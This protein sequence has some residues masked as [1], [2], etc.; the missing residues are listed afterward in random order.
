MLP[1][2]SPPISTSSRPSPC[3][4]GARRRNKAGAA[5]SGHELVL[6]QSGV[7]RFALRAEAAIRQDITRISTISTIGVVLL[8]IALFRGLRLVLLS[9]VL[10]ATG[11]T[12]SRRD[13]YKLQRDAWFD[14]LT[15]R[16]FARA[17]LHDP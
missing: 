14:A 11:S 12:T 17:R 15:V 5:E 1:F 7:G 13:S 16:V 10:L 9:L 3:R 2:P 8:F 4:A 6:R